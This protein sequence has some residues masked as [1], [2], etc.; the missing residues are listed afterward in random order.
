MVGNQLSDMGNDWEE[1]LSQ[2]IEQRQIKD[3]AQHLLGKI[4]FLA[5]NR[6]GNDG[7]KQL[8]A[9]C[10]ISKRSLSR[11]A[12]VYQ[13]YS[14]MPFYSVTMVP[15]AILE[16]CMRVENAYELV[17]KA[18]DNNWSVEKTRLEVHKLTHIDKQ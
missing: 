10:G 3:H 7:L 15:F 13:F 1:L 6:F 16:V 4:A 18:F 2:A 17:L 8:A 11:Y 5:K 14:K 9:S 12:T